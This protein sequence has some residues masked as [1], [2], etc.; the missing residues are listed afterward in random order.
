M[1]PITADTDTALAPTWGPQGLVYYTV[2]KNY[3]P[4]DLMPYAIPRP[5]ADGICGQGLGLQHG[6]QC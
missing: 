5:S 2:S 3:A 1:T 6:V 4:Y